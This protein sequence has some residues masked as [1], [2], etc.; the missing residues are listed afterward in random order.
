M[1]TWILLLLSCSTILAA[2]G[3]VLF[4][5]GATDRK[6]FSEFFNVPIL[7]GLTA[8]GASTILWILALSRAKL[9]VVYPFTALTFVLVYLGAVFF[10]GETMSLGAILGVALVLAGLFLLASPT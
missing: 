4:K 6:T 10:L 8:Y 5:V 7:V 3:Q 2:L 1:R 9:T